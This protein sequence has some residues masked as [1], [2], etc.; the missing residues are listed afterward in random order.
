MYMYKAPQGPKLYD[1]MCIPVRP[2]SLIPSPSLSPPCPSGVCFSPHTRQCSPS[3]P[4]RTPRTPS[5]SH[6]SSS[7][8]NG[9]PGERE[10]EREGG[11][12]RGQAIYWE[13]SFGLSSHTVCVSLHTP[14]LL[15]PGHSSHAG[16]GLPLVSLVISSHH[17]PL[18]YQLAVV[19]AYSCLVLQ[20]IQGM[21]V[22]S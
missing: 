20:V 15:P 5:P 22:D 9:A 7:G 8:Q 18:A 10:G 14:R 11:R 6:C 17:H 21:Q 16:L 19:Q 12:E 13:E 3:A 2:P 4:Q 1:C